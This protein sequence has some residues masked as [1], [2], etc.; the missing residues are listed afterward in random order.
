MIFFLMI[1]RPPRSTLFPYTTLFR[2]L[3]DIK[4]A[5]ESFEHVVNI[6]HIHV[7]SVGEKDI[8]LE[9]HVNIDNMMTVDSDLLREKI[10]KELH[11]K[12]EIHHATIQFECGKCEN[13]GIIKN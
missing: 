5:V 8:H 10:E 12:F 7:W 9:A 11:D 2:S 3:N 4:K 6:H 1:R 13:D